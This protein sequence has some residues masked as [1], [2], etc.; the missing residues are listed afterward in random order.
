M[1]VVINEFEVVAEPPPRKTAESAASTSSSNASKP[2][3][4]A[5]TPHDIR[6]ILLHHKERIARVRT[7]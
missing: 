5:S 2:N 7:Y 6:Q 1:T 4:A 3:Q